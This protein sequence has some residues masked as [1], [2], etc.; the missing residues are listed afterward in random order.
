M[1][2]EKKRM[3]VLLFLLAAVILGIGIYSG[4]RA[5][6]INGQM[7]AASKAEWLI[8]L[9]AY[10]VVQPVKNAEEL[11]VARQ[12]RKAALVTKEG[13][14][15]EF[16]WDRIL[17]ELENGLIAVSEKG[18]WGYMDRAGTVRVEPQ[19]DEA[20][21]FCGAYGGVR[22]SK[23]CMVIDKEGKTVYET[24]QYSGVEST[25][26]EGVFRFRERET[27]AIQLIDIRSGK[28]LLPEKTYDMAQYSEGRWLLRDLNLSYFFAGEDL[29]LLE[30]FKRKPAEGAQVFSDGLAQV[31]AEDG[32][33]G[34]VEPLGNWKIGPFY[35]G[36]GTDF[37][38]GRALLMLKNKT[39]L[40]DRS[41][42]EI[43][44]FPQSGD[45]FFYGMGEELEGADMESLV[46]SD[47]RIPVLAGKK[48]GF[49]DETGEWKVPP[50]F[51]AVSNF[52]EGRAAV[53]IGGNWGIIGKGEK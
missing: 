19:Y 53:R 38:E 2:K 50:V 1:K 12:G 17:P 10:D 13:Q 9:G 32:S 11:Y 33:W 39:L 49:A 42:K 24:D 40:I 15:T 51:D 35:E 47:G 29:R 31:Y 44:R 18:K 41:G 43:K 30:N 16:C 46:F 48:F 20:G 52:S 5:Y 3:L 21:S 34:Y 27:E 14:V 45:S 25:G 6:S 23:V 37:H 36:E 7:Q 8:P 28:S 4:C 22:K 26:K